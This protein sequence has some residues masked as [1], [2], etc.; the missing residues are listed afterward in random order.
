[1]RPTSRP[2]SRNFRPAPPPEAAW[3]LATS[4]SST[5]CTSWAVTLVPSSVVTPWCSHCHTCAREI[6]AVA[7]SSILW[8]TGMHPT[9]R[10]QASVYS[11]STPTFSTSAARVLR[12][13]W[14]AA[15]SCS[16]VTPANSGGTLSIWLGPGMCASKAALAMGTRAGWA[17]QVPSCPSRASRSLS[18]ATAAIA[19]SF[20]AF[21]GAAAAGRRGG[22]AAGRVPGERR[23]CRGLL[24]IMII[25]QHPGFIHPSKK[26]EL[27]GCLYLCF[28]S[29]LRWCMG[30]YA[31]SINSTK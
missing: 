22:K 5:D 25:Y 1:M 29:T 2:A 24:L 14:G 19:R 4:S 26:S 15:N 27:Q 16:S 18:A 31:N 8:C 20:T 9:P 10:S 6:S 3:A 7:A 30:A 11:S 13:P 12:P 23:S 17:T 21:G 28:C